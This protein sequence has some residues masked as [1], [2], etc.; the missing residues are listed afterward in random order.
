MEMI[1]EDSKYF[2]ESIFGDD[3]LRGRSKHL[4]DEEIADREEL[5]LF[6]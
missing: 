5:A 6:G 4:I 1:S 3:I 2:E